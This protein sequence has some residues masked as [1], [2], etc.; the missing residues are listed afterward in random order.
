[1]KKKKPQIPWTYQVKIYNMHFTAFTAHS[2]Y[3]NFAQPLQCNQK[4]ILRLTLFHDEIHTYT[5]HFQAPC[6]N[7]LMNRSENFNSDWY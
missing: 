6:H 3:Y 7:Q 1:M 2:S 5:V 4:Y